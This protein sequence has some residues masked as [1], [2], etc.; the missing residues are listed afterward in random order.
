VGVY[1]TNPEQNM[2]VMYAVNTRKL[3]DYYPTSELS[4]QSS[5][6]HI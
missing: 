1:F 5:R 4:E 6:M 3:P 2:V